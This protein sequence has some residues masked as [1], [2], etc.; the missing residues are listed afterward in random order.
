MKRALIYHAYH[1]GREEIENAENAITFVRYD[2]R[3]GYEPSMEYM[4]DES[5]IREKIAATEKV[6]AEELA[7]YL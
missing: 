6:L 7:E 1:I 2:S 3:L 5:H 4:A